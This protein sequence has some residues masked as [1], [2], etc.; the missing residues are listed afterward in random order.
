[1]E[2]IKRLEERISLLEKEYKELVNKFIN[3]NCMCGKPA[4]MH[5]QTTKETL[6]EELLKKIHD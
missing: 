3:F 4:N 2:E 1:M 6:E 5:L